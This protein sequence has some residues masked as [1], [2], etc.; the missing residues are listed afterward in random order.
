MEE[1][2]FRETTTIGI[3]GCRWSARCCQG[4]SAGSRLLWGGCGQGVLWGMKKNLSGIR[5]RS[6][7]CQ[8]AASSAAESVRYGKKESEER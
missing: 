1:I 8:S 3:R 7:D 5:E 6:K 4:K 2:I